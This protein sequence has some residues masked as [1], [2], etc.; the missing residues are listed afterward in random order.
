MFPMAEYLDRGIIAAAGSDTPVTVANPLRGIYG[1]VTRKTE[2]GVPVG[3]DQKVSVLEAIRAF[4]YN[5]AY[6]SFEEKRKGSIEVGRLADL[7]VLDGSILSS[8]LEEILSLKPV[9]TMTNGEVVFGGES[10]RD[11]EGRG[12]LA[13]AADTAG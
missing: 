4:T 11:L 1:A 12:D 6:A 8:S 7:V 2:S 9:L 10:D 5:G 3:E 13:P